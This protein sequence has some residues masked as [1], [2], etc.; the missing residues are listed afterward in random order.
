[1]ATAGPSNRFHRARLRDDV[2]TVVYDV[3]TGRL[4]EV[5]ALVVA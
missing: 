2:T 4:N 1:M 5:Q 3:T